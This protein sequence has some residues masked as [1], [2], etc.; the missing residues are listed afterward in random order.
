MVYKS[1]GTKNGVSRSY[2]LDLRGRRENFGPLYPYKN[3][4]RH[5]RGHS[6]M[7]EYGTAFSGFPLAIKANYSKLDF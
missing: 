6:L 5:K 3:A 4:P 1:K 2:A 7:Q